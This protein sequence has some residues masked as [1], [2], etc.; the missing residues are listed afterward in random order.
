MVKSLRKA[1]KQP[2]PSCPVSDTLRNAIYTRDNY[3]CMY[4]LRFK[5]VSL[6]VDHVTPRKWFHHKATAETV[7]APSNLVTACEGCNN[8]KGTFTLEQFAQAL[9]VWGADKK[10]VQAMVKRVIKATSTELGQ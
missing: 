10:E 5:R 9:I 3:T 4:C 8:T 2:V 7:N 6:T 1:I